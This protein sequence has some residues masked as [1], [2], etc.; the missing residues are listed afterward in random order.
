[1][2]PP[3]SL[4]RRQPSCFARMLGWL[5]HCLKKAQLPGHRVPLPV[6]GQCAVCRLPLADRRLRATRSSSVSR[7]T[8]RG[9]RAAVRHACR[10]PGSGACSLLSQPCLQQGVLPAEL[11][12][13]ALLGILL[14]FLVRR[15]C[16]CSQSMEETPRAHLSF[17]R[18]VAN[19]RAP[20]EW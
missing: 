19:A 1:V 4:P 12:L 13:A 16:A 8:V 6:P 18:V 11:Q 17:K 9:L 7:A 15:T 5:S 10:W 20:L 14:S 2:H 3:G